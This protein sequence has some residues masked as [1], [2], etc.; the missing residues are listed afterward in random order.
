VEDPISAYRH[1]KSIN[2]NE[3]NFRRLCRFY[4][5]SAEDASKITF[6]LRK[7]G[8]NIVVFVHKRAPPPEFKALFHR[9]FTT[10]SSQSVV[11]DENIEIRV[12]DRRGEESQVGD[13]EDPSR[14]YPDYKVL[15][16]NETHVEHLC[17]YYEAEAEDRSWI[18]YQFRPTKMSVYIIVTKRVPLQEFKDLLEEFLRQVSDEDIVGNKNIEIRICNRGDQDDLG[19]A[20]HVEGSGDSGDEAVGLDDR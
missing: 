9:F 5:A 10:K 17:R 4:E 8:M 19:A 2:A 18:F 20:Q 14:M 12:G 1:W 15:D 7:T 13:W 6:Q 16:A 11:R 3:P